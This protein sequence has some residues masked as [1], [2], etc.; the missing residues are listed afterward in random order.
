MPA[1]RRRGFT[2][3]ELLVVIAI[4]AVLIGLLLPAVQKVREAAARSSCQNNLKQMGLAALNYESGRGGLPPSRCSKNNSNLPAIPTGLNRGNVLVFL[5]PFIEQGSAMALYKQDKDYADP[6]N[7][8]TGI[9][10][11][12]FKAYQCPSTPG[13]P[14]TVAAAANTKYITTWTVSG[15]SVS[16]SDTPNPSGFDG[17]AADYAAFVQLDYDSTLFGAMR[18]NTN[19]PMTFLQDGASNTTLFAEF[20][21]KPKTYTT[22]GKASAA[23]DSTDAAKN[24]WAGQDFVVKLSGTTADGS[25]ASAADDACV[26]NCNNTTDAYGFH[27]GVCNVVFADGSVRPLRATAG[28]KVVS[29][30]VTS[31][32][33]E[34]IDPN[35]Y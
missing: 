23:A 8:G 7:T 1:A 13:P 35:A 11:T 18:Q 24:M 12:V 29:A 34:L 20:A 14:R 26:L 5:L 9:L 6:A 30:L 27:A 28:R 2:L 32:G 22:G 10:K 19:T 16:Y 33:G 3:I 4:I 15:N 17:F 31:Q 21:G 25:A